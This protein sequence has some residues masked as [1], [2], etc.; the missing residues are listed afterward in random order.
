MALFGL[1]V[2]AALTGLGIGGL[3]IALAAQK[4]LENII[5][6]VSLLM[7]KAV[8]VG[9]SCQIGDRV[10][11]VEDI[12]LRSLKL[13][14][15]DQN[16]LVIPNGALA[17]MQFENLSNR[18]KFL[19]K[20]KFSL[21]IETKV[22]QLSSVLDH[23]QSMLNQHPGIESNSAS[24]RIES[25]A[26]A[27][28]EVELVAYGNTADWAEFTCIRQDVLMKIAEIVDASGTGFAPLTRLIYLSSDDGIMR[29]LTE[30]RAGDTTEAIGESRTEAE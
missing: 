11:T 30:P 9:D 12:G 29:R 22:D 14:T 6:G 26:G 23:M 17:Q 28:F 19:I 25:F 15:L 24:V 21:R 8:S 20:Q 3:A 10:G 13:R 1:N 7:D 2:G 16:L 18:K 4:T 5:G 27:A